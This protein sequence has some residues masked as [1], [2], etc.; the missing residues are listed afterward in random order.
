[1]NAR[2][3]GLYESDN[4]LDYN[5]NSTCFY[6]CNFNL[7]KNVNKKG[8]PYTFNYRFKTKFTTFAQIL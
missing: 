2:Q 7:L 3:V 6:P 4:N 1:M 8:K 5:G